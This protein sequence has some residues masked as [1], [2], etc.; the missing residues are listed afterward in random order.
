MFTLTL[1]TDNAA[2]DDGNA[3]AETARILRDCAD[4]IERGD[5]GDWT[6]D[7]IVLSLYDVNGNRVGQAEIVDVE[8]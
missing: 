8:E 5:D 2:F 6:L 1:D 3:A 4:R 7:G